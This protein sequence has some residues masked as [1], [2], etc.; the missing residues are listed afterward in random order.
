MSQ[1][2]GVRSSSSSVSAIGFPIPRHFNC[3]EHGE[4]LFPCIDEGFVTSQ[5]L[6]VQ[7]GFVERNASN[8]W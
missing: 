3:Q 1:T 7:L 5:C 6:R 8:S 4:A 2:G